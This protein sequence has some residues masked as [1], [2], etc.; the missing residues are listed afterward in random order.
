MAAARLW[1][2][3]RR[4]IWTPFGI[5]QGQDLIPGPQTGGPTDRDELIITDHE[6]DPHILAHL[7]VADPV[8]RHTHRCTIR[9][10]DANPFEA[11]SIMEFRDGKVVRERIYYGEP[12]GAAGVAGPVGRAN[13]GTC[14]A[15]CHALLRSACCASVEAFRVG[16]R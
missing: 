7:Q 16:V 9:Y 14:L 15:F 8:S 10:N 3:D 5:G 13:G 1:G 2:E 11:V 6:A 4:E 12:W